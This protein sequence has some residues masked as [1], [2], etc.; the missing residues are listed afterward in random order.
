MRAAIA[1]QEPARLLEHLF[2]IIVHETTPSSQ[3]C[4]TYK[5]INSRVTMMR[6]RC[7]LSDTVYSVV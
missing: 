4:D 7:F 3:D 5:C 1:L 2:Y 6:V